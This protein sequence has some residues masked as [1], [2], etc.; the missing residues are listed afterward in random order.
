[1]MTSK[2][3]FGDKMKKK[4]KKRR[5]ILIRYEMK[6]ENIYKESSDRVSK[7]RLN[8]VRQVGRPTLSLPL[9]LPRNERTNE[10]LSRI[11]KVQ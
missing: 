6:E 9:P 5:H 10:Q 2:R 7:R 11:E 3:F 8:L 1:M 4:V